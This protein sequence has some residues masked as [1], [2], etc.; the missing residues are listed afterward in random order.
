MPISDLISKMNTKILISK[1]VD[2][3]NLNMK[4]GQMLLKFKKVHAKKFQLKSK[5][6]FVFKHPWKT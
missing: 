4:L 3:H 5:Q 1:S 2:L 6:F